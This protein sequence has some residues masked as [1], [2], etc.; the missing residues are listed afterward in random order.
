MPNHVHMILTVPQHDLGAVMNVL[1]TSVSRSTNTISGR[2]GHLFGGPY[3]WSLISS[4]RYFGH[5]LKYVYRNP[6]KA[7]ICSRV[8]DYPYS[9]LWGLFGRERLHFPIYKTRALL[10]WALPSIEPI[11]QLD[12]LNN[13]FPG[14]VETLIQKGLRKPIF[15][16]IKDR[17]TRFAIE[18]LDSL[19]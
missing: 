18:L 7:G 10:E 12:W 8:E 5:A 11:G 2:S 15:D 9:T 1:L 17:R 13:P 3:H 14:E 19:L 16:K 4:S 6:V